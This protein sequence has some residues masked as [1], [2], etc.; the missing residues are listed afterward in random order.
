MIGPEAPSQSP[1]PDGRVV[2]FDPAVVTVVETD[3]DRYFVFRCS[4][5][6]R[7]VV[8]ARCR[9][10]GGP[11][12]KAE[13]CRGGAALKCPWHNCMTAAGRLVRNAVPAVF[14]PGYAAMI[15]P[16]PARRLRLLARRIPAN[17]SAEG[18]PAATAGSSR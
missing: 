15:L 2:G 16:A 9:H 7:H 18:L 11:L 4:E 5:A 12:D 8:D 6:R 1:D 14:R 10:R 13:R 3:E 17:E